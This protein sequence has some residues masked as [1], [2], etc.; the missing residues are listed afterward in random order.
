MRSIRFL[1]ASGEVTGSGFILTGTNNQRVLVDFGMFQGTQETEEQNRYPLTFDVENISGV[2]LTH[3]HLDHCGRLP[4][5][6]KTGYRGK[7][8]ATKPTIDIATI[9]LLDSAHISKNENSK[10][11]LYTEKD[12]HQT[13]SLFEPVSYNKAFRLG[14]FTVIYHDAGHILGSSSIEVFDNNANRIVLS[15]DLGNS[16]QDL[17]K[18][19][20]YILKAD[21]VVMEST[22]G[23]KVHVKEDVQSILQK[24][25]NTV[26]ENDAT[27]LIPA[28]S[29][30]RTQEILHRIHHLKKEKKVHID[31]P[32]FL[33]SPMAIAVTNVMKHYRPLYNQ[34]LLH[35]ENPFDFPGFVTTKTVIESKMIE[36]TNGVKVIIAGSGMMSGGRILGHLKLYGSIASTRI[37]IVG[38]QA[39][40]TLGRKVEEKEKHIV[41][42]NQT[43]TINATVTKIES[44]SSHADQPKLLTWLRKIKGVKKV[45]L[46]HGENKSRDV[47]KERIQKDIGIKNIILP[48]KNE[49]LIL[50]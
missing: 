41:I 17:I 48:D 47:L 22:Y 46:V 9:S 49:E 44:L 8:F 42:N 50:S 39:V 30:E 32:V 24:E 27:L 37:C 31:T 38:Y 4:I 36:K 11:P 20:S 5:L 2:L 45:F 16:P 29:I 23:D 15:G 34:E 13:V 3:A 33:D 28:F 10:I 43:L 40:E 12:V 35:D 21:Y 25:I 19:T 14:E 18:P 26:E 7:I 6:T 1:G